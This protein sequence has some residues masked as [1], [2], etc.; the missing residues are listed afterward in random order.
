VPRQHKHPAAISPPW[1]IT[2]A[3]VSW[4]S[5]LDTPQSV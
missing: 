3:I 4:M 5:P 1:W 2:V